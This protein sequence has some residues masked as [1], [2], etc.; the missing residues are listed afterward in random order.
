MREASLRSL[1]PG[2]MSR[3]IARVRLVVPAPTGGRCG[4]AWVT[5]RARAACA[6]I[7]GGAAARGASGR[8]PAHRIHRHRLARA[9]TTGTAP[10][11]RC[12]GWWQRLQLRPTLAHRPPR[13]APCC[14]SR[15]R[16]TP[17]PT[18]TARLQPP[19][20]PHPQQTRWSRCLCQLPRRPPQR[21]TPPA[22]RAAAVA[23]P[24]PAAARAAAPPPP[25]PAAAGG[26]PRH[27]AASRSR[28]TPRCSGSA[29]ARRGRSRAPSSS[30]RHGRRWGRQLPRG[31]PLGPPK[32]RPAASVHDVGHQCVH[33]AD[34]G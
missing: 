29:A 3:G 32:H 4:A 27:V 7:W 25:T 12:P 11:C 1:R 26:A 13:G 14:S 23:P 30:A 24:P 9:P 8:R 17:H 18:T 5:R 2:C 15:W 22:A 16:G 20:T 10:C 19:C 28:V 31:P 21:M 34:S 33:A 6:L